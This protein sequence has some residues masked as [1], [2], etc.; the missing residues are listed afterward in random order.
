MPTRL[1]LVLPVL[2]VL[3][4]ILLEPVVQVGPADVALL[5]RLDVL[6]VPVGIEHRTRQFLLDS[7]ALEEGVDL[8]HRPVR[9]DG[10]LEGRQVQPGRLRLDSAQQGELGSG[11]LDGQVGL[12]GLGGLDGDGLRHCRLLLESWSGWKVAWSAS[13]YLGLL[14]LIVK[15][16]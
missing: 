7:D 9:T 1:G 2:A 6:L 11:H 8:L 13:R 16:H 3:L 12:V 15:L 4:G 5:V 10:S 14:Y